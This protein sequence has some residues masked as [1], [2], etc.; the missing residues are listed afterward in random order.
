M[1]LASDSSEKT[2]DMK[3]DPEESPLSDSWSCGK[4]CRDGQ[5]L[6]QQLSIAL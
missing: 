3:N 2:A 6:A 1:P 5:R 4:D